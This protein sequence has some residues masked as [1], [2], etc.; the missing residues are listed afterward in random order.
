[1]N[2]INM[3]F[4]D[5]RSDLL[6]VFYTA[7][8]PNL[9]STLL[10][11]SELERSG[12]D[13]V[14]IGMPFSDPLADGPTI[15]ASSI[16]A[17]ENGMTLTI[18][19]DQLKA[20]RPGINIPVLLMG[21]L[22]PV[23]RYGMTRFIDKCLESGIDGVILPDLPLDEYSE[24]YHHLF[25]KAGI[26]NVFLVSPETSEARIRAIDDLSSGFIYL[27]SSSSTTG[28]S[29]AM[30][31]DQISFFKRISDLKLKNP[32]MVGFG[33]S[34]HKSFRLVNEHAEGA[35]IGS[36][37]IKILD[38]DPANLRLKIDQFIKNIRYGQ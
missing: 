25:E 17:R 16:K 23:Y 30:N 18:L 33:I 2:R 6:S 36:A 12:A 34:D 8:Y 14:E 37:F 10:V 1:M 35:I 4:K 32:C 15:Q 3:L 20:L 21:Y 29:D 9:E 13:M 7:G 31:D 27:V 22:N 19:F 38:T 5:G 24:N 28:K 11:A 26:Y